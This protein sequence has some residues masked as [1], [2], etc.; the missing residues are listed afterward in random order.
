MR[1]VQVDEIQKQLQMDN[2]VLLSNLAFNV[3]GE[4][5]NCNTYDVA[6]HAATELGADKIVF[7]VGEEVSRFR[8]RPVSPP[9]LS[10]GENAEPWAV[11]GKELFDDGIH[12]GGDTVPALIGLVP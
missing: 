8:M 7:C 1:F 3:A 9:S 6:V 12:K 10:L 2:V 11:Q 5:L 4:V